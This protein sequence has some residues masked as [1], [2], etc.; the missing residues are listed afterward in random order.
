[1]KKLP[2]LLQ[3]I[4]PYVILICGS[5]AMDLTVGIAYFYGVILIFNMVYAFLLPKLGFDGRRIL[6]WNLLLKLCN[7]PVVLCIMLFALLMTLVGGKDLGSDVAIMFKIVFCVCYVLQ[8]STS[9]FGLSGLL[10]Y[11]K[12]GLLSVKSVISRTLVQLIPL[13][14]IWGSIHCYFSLRQKK[15]LTTGD[16]PVA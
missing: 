6:F 10:C 3:L 9:I 7:I 5:A 16:E 12:Q 15:R 1:M 2:M 11:R 13:I 4:V 8:L 14:G